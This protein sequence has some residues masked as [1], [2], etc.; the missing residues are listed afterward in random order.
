[1]KWLT[2]NLSTEEFNFVETTNEIVEKLLLNL[3]TSGL[4]TKVIKSTLHKKTEKDNKTY[5]TPT[6]ILTKLF[7]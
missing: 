7:N 4:P 6:I 3:D 1:M 2:E 5:G